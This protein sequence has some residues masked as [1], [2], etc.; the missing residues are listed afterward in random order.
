[1]LADSVW[2]DKSTDSSLHSPSFTVF[3][4]QIHYGVLWKWT[5]SR[6]ERLTTD[7]KGEYV[8]AG[9]PSEDLQKTIYGQSAA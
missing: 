3:K 5:G 9:C 8:E 1:M 7:E 6:F 2:D 4:D